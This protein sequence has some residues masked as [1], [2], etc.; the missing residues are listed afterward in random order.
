MATVYADS[1]LSS[2]VSLDDAA[3]VPAPVETADKAAPV[4]G[5][6]QPP[7]PIVAKLGEHGKALIAPM[8]GILVFLG[9]WAVL[10][11]QVETS[12]GALPGP[13]EVFSQGGR[14][15]RRMAGLATGEG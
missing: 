4:T 15:V 7:H 6:A 8:L 3:Q 10:A 9:L 11:P 14:A 13:V 5:N 2:Q 1:A 12:L